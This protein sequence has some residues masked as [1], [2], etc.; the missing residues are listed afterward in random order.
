MID[1]EDR[2]VW[3]YYIEQNRHED[4]VKFC[5]RTNSLYLPKVKGLY[6]D[7]LFHERKSLLAADSYAQS[8]RTFEEISLKLMN[9]SPALQR[10]LEAKLNH[11]GSDMKAQRT[12]LSTWLVEIHLHNINALLMS[13]EDSSKNAQEDLRTFL[14][15][16]HQD[17]DATTTYDLLQSHGRIE[18]WVYFAELKGNFELVMLHHMNQQEFKKALM[19]LEHAEP[20]FKEPL[21][22]RYSPV[23]MKNE[24]KKTV[25]LL[26]DLAKERG[27]AFEAKRL[28]PALMNV[29]KLYREQAIRF[30]VFL[31]REMQV[32]EKSIHNLLIFHLAESD[33]EAL[34]EYF[35]N[36]ENQNELDFDPEY[37]LSVCKQSNRIDALIF[38]YSLLKMYSEAVSIAL[39]NNKLQLA[40]ENA[41][42]PER[43]D[44]DLSRRL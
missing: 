37:A 4:A 32:R 40:K 3:K 39:E 21:L 30:E 20:T 11:M 38:L 44:E 7:F 22:Y 5:E 26:I 8:D 25:D 43:Q 14:S 34:L 27:N 36:Q 10:F 42:K 23:F 17:L 6:A 19:K 15:L 2:D 1:N 9:D 35:E 12:L 28:L 33:E 31:I 24:P 16:H 13:E 41:Q 29:E 18:D